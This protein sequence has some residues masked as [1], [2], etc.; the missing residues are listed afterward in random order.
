MSSVLK[1]HHVTSTLI[2]GLVS[3]DLCAMIAFDRDSPFVLEADK[4]QYL[5]CHYVGKKILAFFLSSVCHCL[6]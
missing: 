1:K 2:I 6:L 5:Y 3:H 4:S